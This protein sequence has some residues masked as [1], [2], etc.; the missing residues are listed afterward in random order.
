MRRTLRTLGR[1]RTSARGITMIEVL[2]TMIIL[3]IVSTMLVGI[4]INLQHSFYFTQS[5]NTAATTARMALDRVSAELRDAQPP[6]T[7][8]TSPFCLTLSSP[9]VC[10]SYDITYYSPYNNPLTA[11]QS[12]P[13][14]TGQAVLQSIYLDTSGT[15]PQKKL[16]WVRDTNGNGAIDSGDQKVLLASNV[17]NTQSTINKPIFQYILHASAN[18]SF[19]PATSLTTTNVGQVCAVNVELVVDAQVHHAPTYMD[20][21]STVRPRN[22][23]TN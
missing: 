19:V 13:N 15:A 4:W 10:D 11:N 2:I 1:L 7:S 5:D 12:Q 8:T 9:Y 3:G 14:G 22:V 20:L 6:N 16:Y 18:A 23:A 21:V 17:V